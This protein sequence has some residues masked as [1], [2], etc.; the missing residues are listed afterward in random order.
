MG[1]IKGIF[2]FASTVMTVWD[3]VKTVGAWVRNGVSSFIDYVKER[4]R[5]R[6][7]DG[8]KHKSNADLER[9]NQKSK[10]TIDDI[11]LELSEIRE[12]AERNRKLTVQLEERLRELAKEREIEAIKRK[13]NEDIIFENKSEY[14]DLGERIITNKNLQLIQFHIGDMP[15]KKKCSICN[16]GMVL[17]QRNVISWFATLDDFFWGC[18]GFFSVN[19]CLNSENITL[20]EFSMVIDQSFDEFNMS[21]KELYD[22]FAT[23]QSRQRLTRRLRNYKFQEMD[24]RCPNHHCDLILKEK[25]SHSDFILDMFYL[26]CPQPNCNYT[27][28]IR[29]LAQ[30]SSILRKIEGSSILA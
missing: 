30:I 14:L 6:E 5:Q 16:R 20:D 9:E 26:R 22:Q 12:R 13:Q 2:S 18:T 4:R 23:S 24:K 8:K 3:T 19:Q 7:D 10:K 21:K 15:I 27:V 29:T 1:W 11:N 25:R 17:R 28:K